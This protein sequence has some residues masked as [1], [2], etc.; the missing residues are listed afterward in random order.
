MTNQNVDGVGIGGFPRGP[1]VIALSGDGAEEAGGLGANS[2]S[3][4][5]LLGGLTT[6]R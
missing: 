4:Q 3:Q 5:Q 2:R 1:I 6:T